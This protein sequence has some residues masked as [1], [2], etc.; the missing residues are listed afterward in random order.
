MTCKHCKE[1]IPT[2]E[3]GAGFV[4]CPF[5]GAKMKTQ[6][7]LK[8]K[9]KTEKRANGLYGK[10]FFTKANGDRG[11][12]YI[13]IQSER[14]I[15]TAAFDDAMKAKIASL[16]EQERRKEKAGLTVGAIFRRWIDGSE[17]AKSTKAAYKKLEKHFAPIAGMILDELT[18]RDAT[19]LV[20]GIRA[21]YSE[22]T[23]NR[24]CGIGR[25]LIQYANEK[26]LFN[27]PLHNV[28]DG[29]KFK[30]THDKQTPPISRVDLNRIEE[31]LKANHGN[32]E[33]MAGLLYLLS[34]TG[35]RV[36]SVE[37]DGGGGEFLNLRKGD[38][39]FAGDKIFLRV[40]NAKT[41]AGKRDVEIIDRRGK[42]LIKGYWKA[43]GEDGEKLFGVSYGRMRYAL[44]RAAAGLGL[45]V[46]L[47]SLRRLHDT[48]LHESG[49]DRKAIMKRLGH[50]SQTMTEYY[51]QADMEKGFD[52]YRKAMEESGEALHLIS[53]Q[54]IAG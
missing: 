36:D 37:R 7:G 27:I 22:R 42:E 15:M 41:E 23:A 51:R 24:V 48:E 35:L 29:I 4:F 1:K 10:A 2:E 12:A 20:D 19:R 11:R 6:K 47:H 53:K 44:K 40:E 5:C 13:K 30:A 8:G 18:Q 39:Y 21:G 46:H 52:E 50:A 31:W 33:Q 28:F 9:Y 38:V 17:K 34:V 26:C 14:E 16:Q 45:D 3:A 32:G 25:A 49:V 54:A 43:A